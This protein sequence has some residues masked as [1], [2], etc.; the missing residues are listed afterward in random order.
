MPSATASP[1]SSASPKPVSASSAW[2]KVWPKLSSAPLAGLALVGRDDGGLGGAAL[3]HRLAPRGGIAREQ[4]R[5]RR[6][7]SQ[8]KKSRS[9]MQPV[10]HHLGIAGE[11]LARRQRGERVD[12]GQHQHRLVERADQV[13]AVRR[14]DRGLAADRAVDLRQQRRRHLYEVD[15]AQQGRGGKAGEVADDAAAERDQRR[16]AL[17]AERQHVFAE[18]REMREI[19]GRLAGRQD[20]RVMRDACLVEPRLQALADGACATFSSVTMMARFGARPARTARPASARRP[21]PMTMS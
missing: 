21:A 7:S 3:Q 5:R 10:F 13:L 12:I 9:P 8:S 4:R 6:C 11:Q 2:P 16:A 15:A 17:D 14:V 1:C 20:D 19:L 18:R